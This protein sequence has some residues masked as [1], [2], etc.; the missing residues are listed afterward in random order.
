MSISVGIVE[1]EFPE[2]TGSIARIMA[3]LGYHDLRILNPSFN[4]LSDDVRRSA[5]HAQKI[6][7]KARVFNSFESMTRG[8]DMIIGTTGKKRK[9]MTSMPPEKAKNKIS[10]KTLVLF[11]REGTGLLNEELK[12][13]DL[14]ITI[15]AS[16]EYPVLNLSHAA[17]IIL[18]T[19]RGTVNAKK[20]DSLGVEKSFNNLVEAMNIK[21]KDRAEKAF[22]RLLMCPGLSKQDM[23]ILAGVFSEC[24]KRIN[25]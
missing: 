24:K 4:I 19:L 18:Y 1:P 12:A 6:I 11:G 9:G 25:R 2:N 13:C 3:N 7:E 17:A 22:K 15:P 8:F 16:K 10:G 23:N 5:K 21:N 14:I 20:E